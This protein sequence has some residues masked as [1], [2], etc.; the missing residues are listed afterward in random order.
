MSFK[1]RL[2]TLAIAQ[3]R[4]WHLPDKILAEVYL[5]LRVVLPQDLENNLSRESQPF[6]RSKGMTCNFT[7]RDPH[8][9]GREHHFIFHV[10]FGQDEESLYIAQGA[11]A[12]ENTL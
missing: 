10:F 11:Y 2:G 6:D 3:I 1:V 8:V 12:Q 5:F 7:R 9:R 4:T